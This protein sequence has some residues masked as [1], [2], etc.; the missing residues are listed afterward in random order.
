MY[1]IKLVNLH[2]TVQ[3]CYIGLF[4]GTVK[5]KWKGEFRLKSKN[6]RSWSRHLRVLFDVPISRN[7]YKTVSKPYENLH[8]RFRTR[9]FE[10]L[11]YSSF[12]VMSLWLYLSC[13]STPTA[14][15]SCGL[16]P[17][18]Y[19]N[20]QIR[21]VFAEYDLFELSIKPTPLILP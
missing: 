10:S 11:H 5:K 19:H 13:N 9:F 7:W 8:V 15:N 14:R 20:F 2:C 3:I 1:S 21:C 6:F 12:K 17:Q 18:G 4:K 16:L